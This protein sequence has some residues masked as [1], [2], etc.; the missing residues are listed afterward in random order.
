MT[1][2]GRWGGRKGEHARTNYN[3]DE[4]RAKDANLSTVDYEADEFSRLANSLQGFF[5]SSKSSKPKAKD[6]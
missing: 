3:V 6:D 4:L 1:G 2:T 5:K